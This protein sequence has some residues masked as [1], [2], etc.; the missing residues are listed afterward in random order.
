[1]LE[2]K[3]MNQKWVRRWTVIGS[4]GNYYTVAVDQ[5]GN[6]GCSCIGW[7][8]HMPRTDCKHI[9]EVRRNPN[10]FDVR[11]IVDKEEECNPFL[12]RYRQVM[13]MK[14][15]EQGD[16]KSRRRKQ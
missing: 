9:R 4:T 2:G 3:E 11:A 6:Y 13:I 15:Q 10:S 16:A 5:D 8:H 1:M 12:P 7:T 14:E